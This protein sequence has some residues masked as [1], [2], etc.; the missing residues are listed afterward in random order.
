[1]FSK[2]VKELLRYSSAALLKFFIACRL[3]FLQNSAKY[4]PKSFVTSENPS[5]KVP[6]WY[7]ESGVKGKWP[8]GMIFCA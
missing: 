6:I 5:L 4:L 8:Y 3:F 1:M 2:G 7:L